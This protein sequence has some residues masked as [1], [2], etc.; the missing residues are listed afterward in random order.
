MELVAVV[1]NRVVNMAVTVVAVAA[2]DEVVK[3][4]V[5]TVSNIL[6]FHKWTAAAVKGFLAMGNWL[7]VKKLMEN[8]KQLA[9]L[10]CLEV[11]KG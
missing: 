9:P 6:L 11:V 1:P 5:V 3:V 2:V 10:E 4:A 7:E 8:D